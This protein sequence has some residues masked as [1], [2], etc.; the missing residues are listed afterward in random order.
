MKI[1]EIVSENK[2]VWRKSGGEIKRGVRCSSGPRAGRVVAK[3]SQCSAKIDPKKR[4]RMK[5]LHA[6]LG[7][8]IARKARRTK[9]TNPASKRLRTLNK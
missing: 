6:R 5:Q 7:A 9:R 1:E 2:A 3:A 8:R 4:A